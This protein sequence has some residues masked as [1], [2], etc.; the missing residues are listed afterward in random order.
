MRS[1][2]ESNY[3]F[4]NFIDVEKCLNLLDFEFEMLQFERQ[5]Y[6]SAPVDE[7]AV[8]ALAAWKLQAA[9]CWC[10]FAEIVLGMLAGLMS[11][12]CDG[13]FA[14]FADEICY[15]LGSPNF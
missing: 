8:A 13:T 4:E 11:S 12:G 10:Q 7:L 1:Y 9:G 2:F 5:D 3:A 14:G 15:C 6:G